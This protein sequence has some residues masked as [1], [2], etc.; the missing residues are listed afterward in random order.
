[1]SVTF[2]GANGSIGGTVVGSTTELAICTPGYDEAACRGLMGDL[3]VRAVIP[4]TAPV[5][6]DPL[7]KVRFVTFLS[8]TF[9]SGPALLGPGWAAVF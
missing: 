4:T 2:C 9:S 6:R 8:N 7:M 5:A 1:L 3:M